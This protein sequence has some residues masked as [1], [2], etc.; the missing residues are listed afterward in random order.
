[1]PEFFNVLPPDE[2]RELLFRH[3]TAVLPAETIAYLSRPTAA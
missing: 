1:M 2:A 3:L